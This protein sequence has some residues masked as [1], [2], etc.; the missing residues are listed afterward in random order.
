MGEDIEKGNA[1]FLPW[2]QVTYVSTGKY[3]SAGPMVYPVL[4]RARKAYNQLSLIEDAIIIY[5]LVRAPERLVFNVDTGTLPRARAEEEVQKIMKR[6]QSKKVYNPTTGTVANGY[7]PHHMLENYFFVKPAGSEGTEVDTLG[8]SMNLG[9]L[10]DLHYFVKKL[11]ISLK[12][13]FNRYLEPTVNIENVDSI[14]Y[15][16]FRF[17]KFIMRIQN[18]FASGVEEGFITHLKLKGLWS[19]HNLRHRDISVV[20]TPPIIYEIYNQQRLLEI[21]LNNY[22]A[23]NDAMDSMNSYAMEKYL[24]LSPDEINRIWR[25]KEEDALRQATIEWKME[26]ISDHGTPEPALEG[27]DGEGDW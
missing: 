18:A 12:I 22:T 7:D 9:E 19:Q 2:D 26:N 14:T 25:M 24:E 4:E 5:R 6:Y 17:A 13:P 23:F 20:F 3:N 27:D 15:E 8:G 11:Y 10:E 21:K 1:I 16:E